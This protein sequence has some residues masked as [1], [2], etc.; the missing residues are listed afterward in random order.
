M[1]GTMTKRV[2]RQFRYM[3]SDALAGYL[4]EM[5]LEGWH[6]TGW[7]VGLC[8]EK[9]EPEDISYSVEVL[10][11]ATEMDMKPEADAEEFSEY[12][13]AAGWKFIDGTRKFSVYKKV[14]EDAERIMT[15]EERFSNIRKAEWRQM[16]GNSVGILTVIGLNGYMWLSDFE[17]LLSSNLL[18]FS[19]LLMIL[20]FALELAQIG[21]LAVWTVRTGRKVRRGETVFYKKM[22]GDRIGKGLLL[23]FV[24]FYLAGIC[25]TGESVYMLVF[26]A[27]IVP[28]F[29]IA[30]LAA[31]LRLPRNENWILQIGGGVAVVVLMI[32]LITLVVI[33][34]SAGSESPSS[35]ME[36]W[37]RKGTTVTM[38]YDERE[39]SVAG[40]FVTGGMTIDSEDGRSQFLSVR[41]SRVKYPV[42]QEWMW[43]Q[44][45]KPA[46]ELSESETEQW[47]ALSAAKQEEKGWVYLK[48]DDKI[49]SIRFFGDVEEID[50]LAD[51]LKQIKE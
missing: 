9:G 34:I 22:A 23:L 29:G 25:F 15:E 24:V 40:E 4:R 16:L 12:C 49:V 48:Y 17:R 31:K 27:I 11:K 20:L 38:K 18:L 50:V 35:D 13:E 6:F 2:R 37:E 1:G 8:F 41:I 14:R 32:P 3:E 46:K 30:L 43:K 28:I 21:F 39:S 26:F 44:K 51:V 10:D 45:V 36:Q 47:K 42:L 5:S 33:G 7:N 19:L